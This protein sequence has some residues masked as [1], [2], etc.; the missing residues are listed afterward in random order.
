MACLLS[1]LFNKMDKAAHEGSA[2]DAIGA[3]GRCENSD[4][5]H[6]SSLPNR[7]IVLIAKAWVGY[8]TVTPIPEAVSQNMGCMES[9]IAD[10]LKGNGFISSV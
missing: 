5:K 8:A 9:A 2:T 1:Q 4:A 6:R 7:C 10:D 3:C